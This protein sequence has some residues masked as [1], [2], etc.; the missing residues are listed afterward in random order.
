MAT[1]ISAASQPM[2]FKRRVTAGVNTLVR[3]DMTAKMGGLSN[4]DT[5]NQFRYYMQ[6]GKASPHVS[7]SL[8]KL[9]LSLIKNAEFESKNTIQAEEFTTWARK[10][11]FTEQLQTMA[12]LTP[13]DGTYLG[14][15]IGKDPAK[16]KLKPLLM[17][18]TSILGEGC[19]SGDT[20]DD[21]MQPEI[22]GILLNEGTKGKE[23]PYKLENVIYGTY[24]AWDSVQ[25]D[26]KQRETFGIYG[27]SLLDPIE[28]SIRNLLNINR[29][30]VSFVK[31]YGMGRYVFDFKL[32]EDLVAREIITLEDAQAAIDE[33]S[34][35]HK[36]LGENEDLIS[37]GMAVT[38]IDAKGSLEVQNFKDSLETDIQI[39]LLQSPLTMG[40]SAGSTYAAGYVAEEDR[41]LVL[42]GLQKIIEDLANEFINKRLGLLRQPEDSVTINFEKLSRIKL[43]AAAVQEMYNTGVISKMQFQK[44]AGFADIEDVEDG[45]TA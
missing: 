7:T 45:A 8:N 22:A 36:N 30:Y 39:G 27:A 35:K 34:E 33:F 4:F 25:L 40:K 23:T 44:W 38:P 11:K 43:D 37:F 31:K 17:P 42:E 29:G 12:R 26:V 16:V 1:E 13:R 5:L 24:N 21:V 20:P 3:E 18:Y 28:Q 41:M 2:P 10:S 19:K 9:G 15:V 14:E 6:L 32:L